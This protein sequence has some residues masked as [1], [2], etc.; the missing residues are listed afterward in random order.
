M[1]EGLDIGDD[2]A[3][4]KHRHR[5][6]KIG[7]VPDRAFGQISVVHQKHV[8]GLH[9]VRRK[10]P[11]HA[12]RHRRIGTSGQLA[13]IAVEQPDPEIMGFADHRRARGALDGVFDL[14]LDRIQR[15]LDDL[16]HDRI[17]RHRFAQRRGRPR[18]RARMHVHRDVPCDE[19]GRI[20]RIPCGS[21]STYWPVVE[22]NS[23]TTAGPSTRPP[24][25]SDALSNT[26][27][28]RNSA[29]K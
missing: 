15:A 20:T 9:R 18:M 13:A 5:A 1:T 19:T 17:D 3:L 21:T 12:V 28:S 25:G 27:V 7:Q 14:G 23:S 6:A 29:P 2:L 24:A 11:H 8:A 22:P 4:V 10:I 26:G 16:Q